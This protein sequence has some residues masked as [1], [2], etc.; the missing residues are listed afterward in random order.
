VIDHLLEHA[1]IVCAVAP[2]LVLAGPFVLRA[3]SRRVRRFAVQ[4]TQ[5]L[6][7]PLLAWPLFVAGMWAL[8]VPAV[9]EWLEARPLAHALSHGAMLGLAVL[10]W[11]PVLGHPRRVQGLAAGVYLL[12][13]SMASDLLGAWYM[14]TGRTG[15]G[16]AMV[17]GMLPIALA[18]VALTWA[19]LLREERRTARWEA[20]ADAPR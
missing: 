9:L 6:T 13:A 8:N 5:G 15:A 20:Y 2:G 4:A 11:L 10:F 16:V 12:T 17:A 7:R 18:A 19:G 14:A 3:L 1:V